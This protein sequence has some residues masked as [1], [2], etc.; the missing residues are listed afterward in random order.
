MNGSISKPKNRTKKKVSETTG[1]SQSCSHI[2]SGHRV[3]AFN[4]QVLITVDPETSVFFTTRV[5][6]IA[7]INEVETSAFQLLFQNPLL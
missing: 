5:R 2:A 1:R 7:R 3:E 4:V 6:R